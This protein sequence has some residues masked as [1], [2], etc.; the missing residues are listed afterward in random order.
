MKDKMG[1]SKKG[2]G[3]MEYLMTYGWAILVV[4]VVGIVLWYL[5]VF[6]GGPGDVNTASGFAKVKPLE[7]SIKYSTETY[8]VLFGGGTFTT[9]RVNLVNGLGT[10]IIV[11]NITM[12]GDCDWQSGLHYVMIDNNK[13][14]SVDDGSEVYE[15]LSNGALMPA[16]SPWFT[17]NVTAGGTL[18]VY[19]L[20]CDL[21]TTD[22][23]FSVPVTITYT[24]TVA[25]TNIERQEIGT[26]S[27]SAE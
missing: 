20:N 13:D 25:G 8:S 27:G 15:W 21:K 22:Q 6:S 5:G 26:I 19:F 23:S 10:L 7:P 2:Q 4:M 17:P 1:V 18:G 3:A 14:G 9:L 11:E 16:G 12:G 24:H